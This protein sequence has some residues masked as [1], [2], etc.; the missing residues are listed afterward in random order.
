MNWVDEYKY[1]P[2]IF[3]RLADTLAAIKFRDVLEDNFRVVSAVAAMQLTQREYKEY[4]EHK[5][6]LDA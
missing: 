6:I 3:E 1:E 2:D 5:N 4:R